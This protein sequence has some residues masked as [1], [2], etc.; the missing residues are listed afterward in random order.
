MIK[1]IKKILL[2]TVLFLSVLGISSC[3]SKTIASQYKSGEKVYLSTNNYADF[4][5]FDSKL[6]EFTEI[7]LDKFLSNGL[8]NVIHNSFIQK[9]GLYA[10]IAFD[11]KC[12]GNKYFSYF[13]VKMVITMSVDVLQDDGSY[14]TELHYETISLDECGD[15]RMTNTYLFAHKLRNVKNLTCRVTSIEGFVVKK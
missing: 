11:Y 14:K 4:V 12:S 7:N 2:I 1:H 3:S 15:G 10:G 13:N 8:I 9:D 5:K 6:I